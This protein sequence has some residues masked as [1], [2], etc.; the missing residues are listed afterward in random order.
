MKAR[1]YLLK[2]TLAFVTLCAIL[3]ASPYRAVAVGTARIQLPD[4]DVKFY[5]NVFIRIKNEAMAITSADGVGTLV[6]GKAACT[7]VGELLRCIPYDATLDQRGRSRHI[8]L[9][10]GTVYVNTSNSPQTL[11]YS[12]TK[13]PPR[14]VLLSV[15]SKRGTYVSLSGVIDQVQK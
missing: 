1:D 12:S 7:R 3:S 2:V 8:A 5:K 13:I 9:Q 10:S 6:L 14:G 4:G 11:P 15:R